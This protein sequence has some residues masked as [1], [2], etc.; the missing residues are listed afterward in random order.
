MGD[1]GDA[2]GGGDGYAIGETSIGVQPNPAR[3]ISVSMPGCGSENSHVPPA[4]QVSPARQA[5]IS[6]AAPGAELW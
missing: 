5:S 1:L 4:S 3:S 2:A 6:S